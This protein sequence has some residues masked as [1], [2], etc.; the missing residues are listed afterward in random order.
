MR[1]IIPI[2]L[3]AMMLPY[4]LGEDEPTGEWLI[5]PDPTMGVRLASA[6][7]APGADAVADAAPPRHP[8]TRRATE[9][10]AGA[11]AAAAGTADADAS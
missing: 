2:I 10:V 11:A 3:I 1:L 5:P 9:A 6:A 7:G 4:A 8:A